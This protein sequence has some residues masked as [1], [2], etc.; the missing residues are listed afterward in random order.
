M[1]CI[2]WVSKW[3]CGILSPCTCITIVLFVY[4]GSVQRGSGHG[5]CPDR[6]PEPGLRPGKGSTLSRVGGGEGRKWGGEGRERRRMWRSRPPT[7]HNSWRDPSHCD[8]L[9]MGECNGQLR[10]S[11]WLDYNAQL[12]NQTLSRARKAAMEGY[13]TFERICVFSQCQV[14]W[15][16]S[17]QVNQSGTHVGWHTT[18]SLMWQSWG[19]KILSISQASYVDW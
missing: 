12:F 11:A 18:R 10:T 9:W 19:T 13:N 14:Y 5:A 6:P 1:L 4:P 17:S 16:E 3:L 8:R 7:L 2:Y 15:V